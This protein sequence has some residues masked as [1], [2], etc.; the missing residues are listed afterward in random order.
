MVNVCMRAP[1]GRSCSPDRDL[2]LNLMHEDG[3]K[4][5]LFYAEA[6][7]IS[8]QVIPS[9]LNRMEFLAKKNKSHLYFLGLGKIAH[10][11]MLSYPNFGG[12]N[13]DLNHPD[14][15]SL[16]MLAELQGLDFR[17]LVLQRDPRDIIASVKRRNFG[18]SSEIRILTQSADA[19]Y[20]QLAL[21]SPS[22]Y[23]C[24]QYAHLNT[25]NE[26]QKHDLS[27]FLHPE[28][29]PD[30]LNAMV[31]RLHYKNDP[32]SNSTDS[33]DRKPSPSTNESRSNKHPVFQWNEQLTGSIIITN[34]MNNYPNFT[35]K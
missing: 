29:I 2:T 12:P 7:G 19:L 24:V 16:A 28:V 30:V 14:A 32:S 21:I 5:G 25:M 20:T 1:P 27:N 18:G 26:R 22:F 23:R 8:R 4:G 15:Y 10:A 9:I 13:K 34:N 17:V 31:G 33:T 3:K 35:T 6:A 11:G